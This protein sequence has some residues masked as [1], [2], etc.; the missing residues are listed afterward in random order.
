MR[1]MNLVIAN[2]IESTMKFKEFVNS[3]LMITHMLREILFHKSTT[4]RYH[5]VYTFTGA[6]AGCNTRGGGKT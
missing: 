3:P 2:S 6:D 4:G 1:P 5:K